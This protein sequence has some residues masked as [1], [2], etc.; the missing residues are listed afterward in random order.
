MTEIAGGWYKYLY[1]AYDPE[2]PYVVRCDAGVV[3]GL[4][5][6]YGFGVTEIDVEDRVEFIYNV[7]SG[8][9]VIVGNQII[10]YQSDNTTEV[11]RFN[12]KDISGN[13]TMRNVFER[14]RV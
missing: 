5:A 8:R 11:A 9:W 7:E 1:A 13:A 12:L 6:R 2:I 14:V 4:T 10:F 3:V